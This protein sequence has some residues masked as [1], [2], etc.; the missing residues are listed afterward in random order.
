MLFVI[1]ERKASLEVELAEFCASGELCAATKFPSGVLKLVQPRETNDNTVGCMRCG[2]QQ[3]VQ[4]GVYD[5]NDSRLCA[6]MMPNQRCLS[7]PPS[8]EI[9]IHPLEIERRLRDLWRVTLWRR[10][11]R[12]IA[13]VRS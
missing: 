9:W 12:L 13:V 6:D 7:L 1:F 11:K 10:K 5:T 8:R 3:H 2:Y 4:E